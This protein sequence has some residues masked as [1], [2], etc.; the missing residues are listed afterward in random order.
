MSQGLCSDAASSESQFAS[1]YSRLKCLGIQTSV[2]ELMK[3]NG[4]FT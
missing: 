3:D 4:I 2:K 1:L